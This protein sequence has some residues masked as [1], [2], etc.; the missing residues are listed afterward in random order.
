ML[1]YLVT[2]NILNI[3][4]VT[5]FLQAENHTMDPSSDLQFAVEREKEAL[6]RYE[7]LY[8]FLQKHLQD[9]QVQHK[10]ITIQDTWGLYSFQL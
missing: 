1:L 4:I 9:S 10:T 8:Q 3:A 2:L 7:E 6:H 5:K